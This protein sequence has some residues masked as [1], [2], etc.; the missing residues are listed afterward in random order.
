MRYLRL[1]SD[2]TLERLDL[3]VVPVPITELEFLGPAGAVG[4]VHIQMQLRLPLSLELCLPE[5]RTGGSQNLLLA[6][7]W[8]MRPLLL[9]IY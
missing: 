7:F 5:G 2:P 9:L 8:H 1:V 4:G 3:V 6:G